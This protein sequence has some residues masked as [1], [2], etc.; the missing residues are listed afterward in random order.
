MARRRA[1][2]PAFD[3]LST[4]S[5]P[6]E[7]TQGKVPDAP[8]PSRSSGDAA[9][10]RA[11]M[12]DVRPL[13]PT[14]RANIPRPKPKPFPRQRLLE[15][16]G[17]LADSLSG[18]LSIEDW[19]DMAGRDAEADGMDSAFLRPGLPRRA[20]IDL[21]RGRWVIQAELDLHGLDRED[22]RQALG[23]FLAAAL[24]RDHR[25]VRIIHGKGLSSP[26]GK[27]V[28]KALSR[29]WLAQ[30]EEVL[31]FCPARPRDGGEGALLALL[32]SGLKR[33]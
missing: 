31:A 30:R 16:A 24:A 7:K 13:P 27:S 28:L 25:C 11:A 10:F 21:R 23:Q 4:L 5:L 12:R 20:L 14:G 8:A 2:H 1:R 17:T 19:L 33:Q 9:L 32:R 22:A 26:G 18:A 6:Q 29:H 3:A 15:E